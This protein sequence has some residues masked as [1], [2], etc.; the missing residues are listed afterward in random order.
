M[1]MAFLLQLFLK[2]NEN[3]MECHLKMMT[4]RAITLLMSKLLLVVHL[5]GLIQKMKVCNHV[6]HVLTRYCYWTL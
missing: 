4:T 1:V 5:G 3:L 6:N 2:M